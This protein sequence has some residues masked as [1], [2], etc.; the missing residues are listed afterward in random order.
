MHDEVLCLVPEGM[1]EEVCRLAQGISARIGREM[2][3]PDVPVRID[4]TEGANWWEC[5]QGDPIQ[6]SEVILAENA[7]EHAQSRFGVTSV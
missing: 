2:F 6:L 3:G 4:I 1:V 7:E 5:S